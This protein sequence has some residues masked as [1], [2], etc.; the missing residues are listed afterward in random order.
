MSVEYSDTWRKGETWSLIVTLTDAGGGPLTPTAATWTMT[1]WLG[2]SV[3]KTL[4]A[5]IVLEDNVATVTVGTTEQAA[6]RPRLHR[7]ELL[8]TDSGGAISR[9]IH[10]TLGV[11]EA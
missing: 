9:Q 1:D 11:L 4:G 3:T 6:I 5:G 10:G 2:N 7:H 8:V